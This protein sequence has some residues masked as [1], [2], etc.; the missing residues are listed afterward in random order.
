MKDLAV[1]DL[2][3]TLAASKLS[4]DSVMALPLNLLLGL[5]TVAV[6]SG[7]PWRGWRKC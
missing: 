7:G 5:V 2:G 4:I 6:I 1:V 3:G